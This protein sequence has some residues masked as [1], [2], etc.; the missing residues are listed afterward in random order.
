MLHQDNN[1]RLRENPPQVPKHLFLHKRQEHE[2]PEPDT[3]S[4]HYSDV[5]CAS[6][7]KKTIMQLF[8]VTQQKKSLAGGIVRAIAWAGRFTPIR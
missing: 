7:A 3:P 4:I 1:P 8:L 6:N 5:V 2:S